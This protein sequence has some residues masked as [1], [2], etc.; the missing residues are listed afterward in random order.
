MIVAEFRK[1]LVPAIP[2]I[3]ALLGDENKNVRWQAVHSL[4]KFS[5]L[6]KI[7]NMMMRH[8]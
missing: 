4:G 1:Y 2:G 8:G 5:E 7:P 6:G 3:I